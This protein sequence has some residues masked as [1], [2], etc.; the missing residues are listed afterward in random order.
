LA[1]DRAFLDAP[2]VNVRG[3]EECDAAVA[4][5]VGRRQLPWP[6]PDNYLGQLESLNRKA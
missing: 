5:L 2:E 6:G 4:M 1:R 3:R